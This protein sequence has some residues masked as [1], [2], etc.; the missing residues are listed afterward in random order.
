MRNFKTQ[1]GNTVTLL[2]VITNTVINHFTDE[3][4]LYEIE[5]GTCKR[6]VTKRGFRSVLQ[7][8]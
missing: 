7:H 1:R 8:S 2:S 6:V 4:K 5:L 3:K